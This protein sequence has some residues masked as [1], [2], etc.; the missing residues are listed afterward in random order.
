MGLARLALQRVLLILVVL[1]D[2]LLMTGVGTVAA[3]VAEQ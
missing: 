3:H 2:P 1:V